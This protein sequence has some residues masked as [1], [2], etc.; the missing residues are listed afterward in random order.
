MKEELE[1]K[2]LASLERVFKCYNIIFEHKNLDKY[3][4][5]LEQIK[6]VD[7]DVLKDYKD[8]FVLWESYRFICADKMLML[9][10][11]DVWKIE[12]DE[13]KIELEKRIKKLN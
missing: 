12:M 8:I 2:I 4:E 6:V 13:M 1:K 10:A 11:R 9:K 7:S 3:Q 5:I